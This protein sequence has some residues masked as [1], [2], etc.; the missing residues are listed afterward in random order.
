MKALIA[1]TIAG[2]LLGTAALADQTTPPAA[3]AQ[4]TA[5]KQVRP[6]KKRT[7]KPTQYVE[8]TGSHIKRPVKDGTHK[9]DDTLRVTVIDPNAPE[10]RGLVNPM[11]MLS[12]NPGVFVPPGGR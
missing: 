11:D 3:K 12:R 1:L 8:V 4:P 10:N 2:L 5:A 7:A 9:T 6:A